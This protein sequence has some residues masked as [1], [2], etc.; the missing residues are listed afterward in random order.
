MKVKRLQEIVLAYVSSRNPIESMKYANKLMIA[1]IVPMLVLGSV[2][3]IIMYTL[4]NEMDLVDIIFNS[5]VMLMFAAAF[6]L[7]DKFIKSENSKYNTYTAAFCAMLIF[8][9]LRYYQ[10]TGPAVWTVAF[11]I[12]LLAILRNNKRM[13][14][15]VAVTVFGLGIYVWAANLQY[16]G[17]LQY[18]ITQFF[19]LSMVFII[20]VGL[21]RINV[22]R[23]RKTSHFLNESEMISYISSDFISIDP[24]NHQQKVDG[25]LERSSS[26]FGA[27]RAT[28]FLVSEGH[29]KSRIAFEWVA[30]GYT[31]NI[32]V[33]EEFDIKSNPIWMDQINN[34]TIWFISNIDDPDIPND[35]EVNILREMKIKALISAPIIVRNEVF[36]MLIYETLSAHRDWRDEHK[37]M[38]VVLT[39]LLGDAF[40]KVEA[41]NDI[42]HMAFYDTLTGLPNRFLFNNYLDIALIEAK[43]GH[44]KVAVV[45][46][47]LD[48][49]KAVND[50]TGHEGGDELL[51]Q[52][53]Y[54]LRERI[55]NKGVIARF[56]GDE[57][58][59]MVP[60]SGDFEDINNIVNLIMGTFNKPMKI[61]NQEFFVTASAGIAIYPEDGEDSNTIIKNA[62]LAMY[63]AKDLGKN[64]AAFCSAELKKDVKRRVLLT[65][66]LYRAQQNHEL[67]LYYQPFVNIT[68]KQI[69]GAEALI[70]W[71]HPEFGMISPNE[72]IPLAEQS[73]LIN[74][75]GK[76][77]LETACRQNKAWQDAGL[78]RF[79]MA[80]N[81]SVEQF[82]NPDLVEIVKNTLLETDLSPQYLELE[83]TESV[84]IRETDHICAILHDLKALGV[85][86]AIDDFGTEY[87]SLARIKQLPID[88][89]KMAMEFVHGISIS[90]KDEAIAK[91]IIILASNL[92]VKV[93]AEGVETETQIE[94]LK[95]R[96][97][98]EVQGFYFYKPMPAE[99]F[100][101]ILRNSVI[102]E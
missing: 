20:G 68:T 67:V 89:I 3:N 77:V 5:A 1:G 9:V 72:F 21:T 30:E 13:I 96:V 51:K 50:T 19:A 17:G 38:L 56:G 35:T 70:R 64:Q 47:D 39:N 52:V 41:E 36:G 81:L 4:L 22:E 11:A 85:S 66:M 45:F 94:F 82:K 28:I 83:I 101:K 61:N 92:G 43:T 62:D 46:I 14:V 10:Y 95:N 34:K 80:V 71:N 37:K 12:I 6:L 16:S 55:G 29:K 99:E 90:E 54:C 102:Q 57:F 31:S 84:A 7:A 91:V 15:A 44:S 8:A 69:I 76:W 88:R 60:Y 63:S 87:S 25:M 42:S 59:M 78:S 100:E 26:Y 2:A 48:A 18:N 33:I 40:A 65:N 73:G 32:G 97:C 79:R 23:Y 93:I 58:I 49:F 74:P 86:I 24:N 98:D 75:I 27:E 53:A